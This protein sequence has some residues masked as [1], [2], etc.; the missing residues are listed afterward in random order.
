MVTG[1][2][3][4]KKTI[5]SV[6]ASTD[7]ITLNDHGFVNGDELRFYGDDLADGLNVTARFYVINK[8]T[9]DFEVS[10]TSGGSAVNIV[11]AG[12]GTQ[13]MSLDPISVYDLINK[14]EKAV[15]TTNSADYL[16]TIT[17]S[18]VLKATS[19]ADYS[20]MLNNSVTVAMDSSVTTDTRHKA[21][22]YVKQGDYGTDYSVTIDGGATDTPCL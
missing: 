4:A 3:T 5:T 2:A 14:T 12:T 9:N 17:P 10:L 20:F 1:R 16:V 22:V 13:Q 15:T 11:D 18:T 8:T 21:Y 7:K 6:N 19:I